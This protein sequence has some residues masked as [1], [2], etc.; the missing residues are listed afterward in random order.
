VPSLH[1]V[2]R[3]RQTSTRVRERFVEVTPALARLP[4]PGH[5]DTWE[6]FEILA[7]LA[8][9]DLSLARL[10][11][12]HADALAIL[13]ESGH[14]SRYSGFSYGVWAA[15]SGTDGVT[16]VPV[17]GGWILSGR[18]PFC[19]GSGVLDRALITAEAPDGY[20]LFDVATADS[21]VDTIPNSWPA[22]GMADS[23]SGTLAIGGPV[24]TDDH[25]IG[26]PGYYTDRPGFWFGACGVAACWYG[27]ARGLVAGVLETMGDDSGELALMEIGKS[28]S[29]LQGMR[30][31]LRSVAKAIDADPEDKRGQARMRALTVRQI[32]HDACEEILSRTAAAGGARPLCHD[33]AQARRA[34]DLY[35]Y[36]AQH[37]G[38]ADAASL[39]RLA[40]EGG[41]R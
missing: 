22:V 32:V 18:K 3:Q 37:H 15:R 19:S 5:G 24:V 7:S 14:G 1:S 2:E 4:L 25:A 23:L 31:S 20:R 12:G 13:N 8:E 30:D 9:E 28:L 41:R 34:A 36:L 39:G 38:G 33:A 26:R 29:G 17:P 27:G 6:R 16:A 21:V 40:V 35:V 11:E 10:G